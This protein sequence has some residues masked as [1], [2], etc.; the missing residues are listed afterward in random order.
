MTAGGGLEKSGAGQS[1]NDYQV[2][3][4]AVICGNDRRPHPA[5]AGGLQ[6]QDCGRRRKRAA[7][8]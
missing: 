3:M 2:E 4:S 5:I 8:A 1:I 6:E 7:R